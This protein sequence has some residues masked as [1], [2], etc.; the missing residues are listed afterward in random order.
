MV[1]RGGRPEFHFC[2][3]PPPINGEDYVGAFE[4]GTACLLWPFQKDEIMLIPSFPKLPASSEQ[5]SHPYKVQPDPLRGGKQMVATQALT[6]GDLVI[7]ERPI[8]IYPT[9]IPIARGSRNS[10]PDS[11]LSKLLQPDLLDDHRRRQ[12][13][14]LHNCYGISQESPL[15]T[16][17]SNTNSIHVGQLPGPHQNVSYSGVANEISRINHRLACFICFDIIEH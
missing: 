6:C 11:Y 9:A 3:L 1:K 15:L 2:T 5:T 16:G 4:E 14:D 8:I 17:I 12:F 13:L 10:H 7:A